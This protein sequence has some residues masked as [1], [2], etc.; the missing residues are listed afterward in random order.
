MLL[1]CPH[2]LEKALV[3]ACIIHEVVGGGAT[4][5]VDFTLVKLG[6]A[7]QTHKQSINEF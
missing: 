6:V 4:V 3:F 1:T 2:N 5:W 7:F